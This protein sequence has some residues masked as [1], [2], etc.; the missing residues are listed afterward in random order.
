MDLI[1][2]PQSSATLL[3]STRASDPA[4]ITLYYRE[5][6]ETADSS[7]VL[8]RDTV[9]G[10]GFRPYRNNTIS[11]SIFEPGVRYILSFRRAGDA[12]DVVLHGGDHMVEIITEDHLQLFEAE[13]Q[14]F[15]IDAVEDHF[16]TALT[17]IAGGTGIRV[18]VGL[19]PAP[20]VNFD[21]SG[22]VVDTVVDDDDSIVF[23]D[24]NDNRPELVSPSDLAD[25]FDGPGLAVTGG[26]AL[27]LGFGGLP[28]ITSLGT[29]D[30]F[31]VH[32]DGVGPRHI[33]FS[34]V[35]SETLASAAL[36]GTPTA[37]T[38]AVDDDSTRLAT[39]AW[40]RDH[41]TAAAYT[42]LPT[43]SGTANEALDGLLVWDDSQS[44]LEAVNIG[45][46]MDEM[47]GGNNT[48]IV[49]VINANT[50][51]RSYNVHLDRLPDF[52]GSDSVIASDVLGI[53][54]AADPPPNKGMV[55]ITVGQFLDQVVDDDTLERS[56]NDIRVK[57]AGVGADQLN[58]G[59][60]EMSFDGDFM[61]SMHRYS[62]FPRVVR[63]TGTSITA[64][65]GFR[66]ISGS[67][68]TSIIG[69]PA[70]STMTSVI[71]QSSGMTCLLRWDYMTASD[72]PS[73]WAVVR[74]DGTVGSVWEAEDP[75]GSGPP[76]S[77][78]D[79]DTGDS[80]VNVGPPP[81][82]VVES[83][84]AGLTMPQRNAA[85]TCTETYVEGRGWLATSPPFGGSL[86]R[87]ADIN[88]RYEP[89]GRQWAMRCLAEAVGKS[90][91]T[92]Y[93]DRLVVAGGAWALPE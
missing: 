49:R 67:D 70:G 4:S 72:R 17:S 75:A 35:R 27:T 32:D 31:A 69:S 57:D 51:Q 55:S 73:I 48:G 3:G 40:V 50:M 14:S 93:R 74:A 68:S 20:V 61:T 76:V 92:T 41:S 47:L 36:T 39:T 1:L 86:A 58:M 78:G 5:D 65:C 13:L 87:L 21:P 64:E 6:T 28:S 54:I 60:G 19:T 59:A 56:G 16:G 43:G 30:L 22:L 26:G 42:D 38:A 62:F 81:L 11:T 46:F 25:Y 29:G 79:D 82:S 23:Y 15:A 10:R 63:E 71:L 84:Y 52:T 53:A 91:T 33:T 12:S 80:V 88:E 37:P 77:P 83:L 2:E 9:D 18:D 44:R 85:I 66:A 24:P 8:T 45:P 89:S 7:I 34:G 90:V